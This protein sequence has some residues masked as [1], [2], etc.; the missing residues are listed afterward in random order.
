MELMDVS[1]NEVARH[2][3]VVVQSVYRWRDH[4]RIPT[5]RCMVA[6]MQLTKGQVTLLDFVENAPP[7]T[8]EG[9]KRAQHRHVIRGRSKQPQPKAVA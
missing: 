5:P 4:I 2:C 8:V 3:G 7:Q 6:L 1:P 9:G